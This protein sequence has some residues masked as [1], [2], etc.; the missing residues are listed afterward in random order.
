MKL[1]KRQLRR[2][3]QEEKR[4]LLTEAFPGGWNGSYGGKVEEGM[5]VM[6]L[7]SDQFA[8]LGVEAPPEFWSELNSYINDVENAAIDR[9]Y[10]E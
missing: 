5:D 10:D 1:S 8:A 9:G 4:K 3:I 2:I 6:Q 7:V